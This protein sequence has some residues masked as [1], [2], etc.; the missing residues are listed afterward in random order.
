MQIVIEIPDEEKDK[1][2]LLRLLAEEDTKVAS[3]AYLYA[4]NFVT[5]GVD[6]TKAWDTATRQS[7]ALTRVYLDGYGK[8]YRKG[9][10]E[11]R[12]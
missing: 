12:D 9:I 3:I 10:N 6:V 7:E 8:G 1:E 11:D 4:T 5:F 2:T